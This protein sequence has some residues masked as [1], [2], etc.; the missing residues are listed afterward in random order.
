MNESMYGWTDGGADG[1]NNEPMNEPKNKA[2][3]EQTGGREDGRTDKRNLSYKKAIAADS[4]FQVITLFLT[5][6]FGGRISGT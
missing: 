3:K 6:T 5:F 1:R 2:T 4:Y